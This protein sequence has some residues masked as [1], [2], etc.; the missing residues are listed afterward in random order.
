MLSPSWVSLG[1]SSDKGLDHVGLS[2]GRI[3]NLGRPVRKQVAS[4]WEIAGN[5]ALTMQ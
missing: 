4:A 2:W 1:L 5:E 3:A